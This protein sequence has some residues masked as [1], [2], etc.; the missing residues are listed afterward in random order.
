MFVCFDKA[1][2]WYNNKMLNMVTRH[3]VQDMQELL[4]HID[5][6]ISDIRTIKMKYQAQDTEL[7]WTGIRMQNHKSKFRDIDIQNICNLRKILEGL[8]DAQDKMLSLAENIRSDVKD[9]ITMQKE[10][11]EESSTEQ[12]AMVLHIRVIN[13]KVSSLKKLCF[14]YEA[15]QKS[16]ATDVKNIELILRERFPDKKGNFWDKFRKRVI[17]NR[18]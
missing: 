1:L 3:G 7:Y 5:K 13:E 9:M 17:K 15:Q 4:L 16:F 10:V 12:E 18:R 6:T 8:L 11:E 2:Q 14:E